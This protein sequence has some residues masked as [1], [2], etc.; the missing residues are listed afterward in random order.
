MLLE[1]YLGKD[2]SLFKEYID[3][4]FQSS[5]EQ[6]HLKEHVQNAYLEVVGVKLPKC[7]VQ[8]VYDLKL[9]SVWPS[10]RVDVIE[11]ESLKPHSEE[12]L[13]EIYHKGEQLKADGK[14]V[15]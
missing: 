3:I 7:K 9:S 13:L 1:E 15:D 6:Q 8:Y 5:D 14:I 10:R 11:Y 2:P 12:E 4:L